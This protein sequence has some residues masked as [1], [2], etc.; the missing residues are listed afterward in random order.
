MMKKCKY[1]PYI[2]DYMAAIAS[3]E[4][5]AGKDIVRAMKLV[6]TK[7]DNPD[8]IIKTEIIDKAV[9]LIERYLQCLVT[10]KSMFNKIPHAVM[11]K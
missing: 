10:N 4:R 1:H 2:D 8:V 3:G 6:K 11:F 9:E 7:L 5:A